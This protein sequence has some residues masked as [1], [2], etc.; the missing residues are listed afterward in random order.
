MAKADGFVRDKKLI[1]SAK[2]TVIFSD[3]NLFCGVSPT[4]ILA[5]ESLWKNV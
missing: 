2:R 5:V 3:V 4:G 1:V